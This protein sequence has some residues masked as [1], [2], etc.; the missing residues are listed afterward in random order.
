MGAGMSE[1][2][3]FAAVVSF[4]AAV[5]LWGMWARASVSVVNWSPSPPQRWP[6]LVA[7][8]VTCAAGIFLVLRTIASHDVVSDPKYILMYLLMGMAWVAVGLRL[9]P[10]LGVSFRHDVLERGNRAAMWTLG[11]A[12]LGLAACF[13]GANVGDGPGWWVVVIAALLSTGGLL[14]T[15]MLVEIVTRVSEAI[16]I[17]RD[18]PSGVRFGGLLLGVGLITGRGAAGDWHS[19]ADTVRDF[20][21]VAWPALVLAAGAIPVEWM[22]RPRGHWRQ[23]SLLMHGLIPAALYIGLSVFYVVGMAAPPAPGLEGPAP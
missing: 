4:V 7:L 15:W 11:G 3:F 23:T 14:V 9:T 10:A 18:V 22:C 5:G 8:P 13:A 12:G 16:V 17:E 2:E 19:L 21:I 20:V 6:M 1:D